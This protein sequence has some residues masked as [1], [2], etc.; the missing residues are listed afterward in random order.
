MYTIDIGHN[1]E[2]AHR[3]DSPDAPK[4]CVSIHGHSWWVTVTI[5]GETLDDD[6]MLV[7]FGAFKKAWRSWLD[8][9]VDHHLVLRQGDPM[10][11]A[12][13][14]VYPDSRLWILDESPT[15]E[16]IARRLW[17]EAS[18]VLDAVR[19]PDMHVRVRRVHVQETRVNAA[20]Y[21]PPRQQAS[22]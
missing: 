3:L 22:D 18:L 11:E 19:P 14:S 16:V 9:H 2:T 1:F 13:R 20:S 17:V 12:V 21:E 5:E 4:K 15:T 10:I 7:E 6:G 8:T